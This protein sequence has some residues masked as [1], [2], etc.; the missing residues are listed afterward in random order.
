MNRCVV[1]AALVV[2]LGSSAAATAQTGAGSLRGYITD[3]Q[4]A[5]MP[6][7]T[8]TARSEVLIQPVTAVSDAEGYYRLIN[9][10]PGSYEVSADLT[11]FAAFKRQDILE[12]ITEPSKVV[13]EQYMSTVFTMTDDSIVA[14]RI[15]QETNDKLVVLTNPFDLAT[16]ATVNKSGIKSRE[17]SK[18]SVMPPGLLNTFSEGEIL[19]LLAFLESMGD[20]KHP[21]FSK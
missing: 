9:L 8:V 3:E 20:P 10:A 16:T 12:S 15:S 18:I 4:G 17:L 6:G 2:F 21:D 1:A 19:D 13:S 14:G 11:G 7:V 5:A